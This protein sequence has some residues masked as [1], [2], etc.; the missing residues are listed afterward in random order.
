MAIGNRR[1]TMICLATAVVAA[2]AAALLADVFPWMTAEWKVRRVADAKADPPRNAG[3]EV[4]VSAFYTGGMAKPDGSDIRVA[5]RGRTLTPH[6]VLQVGPGDL[7]RIT[8]T[9]HLRNMDKGREAVLALRQ[10]EDRL[11]APS[12]KAV[13]AASGGLRSPERGFWVRFGLSQGMGFW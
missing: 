3:A 6:R 11:K 4:A 7:I 2:V 9:E 1:L 12:H 10:L 8:L 13:A 5:I